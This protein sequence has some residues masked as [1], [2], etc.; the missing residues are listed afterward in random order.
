ME[1]KVY[2]YKVFGGKGYIDLMDMD[3]KKRKIEILRMVHAQF[4]EFLEESV[5]ENEWSHFYYGG[6]DFNKDDLHPDVYYVTFRI[7]KTFIGELRTIEDTMF[8]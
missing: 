2:Q 5:P 3:K 8:Q 1:I 7:C 4:L 6:I